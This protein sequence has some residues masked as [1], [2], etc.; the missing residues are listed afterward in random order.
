MG[1]QKNYLTETVLL[2]TQNMFKLM[3]KKII[4][5]IHTESQPQNPDLGRFLLLL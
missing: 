2:S 3:S 4:I 1:S 5:I